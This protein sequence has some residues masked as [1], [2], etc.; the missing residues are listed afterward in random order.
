MMIQILLQSGELTD[1]IQQQNLLSEHHFIKSSYP[2]CKC[3]ALVNPE[4]CLNLFSL[5]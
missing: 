5:D 2:K 1:C 3:L 4:M